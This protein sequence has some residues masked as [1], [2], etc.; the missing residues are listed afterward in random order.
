MSNLTKR[1]LAAA[2]K[3]TL[4]SHDLEKIKISDLTEECGVNRQTFYYHFHDIY[5]LIDWM[6]LTEGE[7]AIGIHRN[8]H[9]WQEGLLSAFKVLEKEKGFIQQ[10]FHSR[11]QV[12]IMRMLQGAAKD[13]LIDVLHEVS[14]GH[15]VSEESIQ[16]IANF[17]K[18]S[19]A[20]VVFEWIENDMKESP[21]KLVDQVATL[22]H[23]VFLD[24]IQKFEDAGN[25]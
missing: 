3:K 2:L 19:F 7:A 15:K 1:A 5:D 12:R 18:F 9:T 14:K 10:T 16:F 8:Y 24:T 20:G 25:K 22:M 11:S 6:Y 17:Y 4:M 23:G 13:L 21:E